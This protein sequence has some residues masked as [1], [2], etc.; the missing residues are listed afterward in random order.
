[1]NS[2]IH[3]TFTTKLP[4]SKLSADFLTKD[5]EILIDTQRAMPIS[6]L[7]VNLLMNFSD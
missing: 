7:S 3:F 1:M 6:I 5:T 2:K 4:S